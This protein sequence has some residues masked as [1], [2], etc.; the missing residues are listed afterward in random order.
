MADRH[1]TQ[2]RFPSQG[3]LKLREPPLQKTLLLH[4]PIFTHSPI[5]KPLQDRVLTN[6]KSPAPR[7]YKPGGISTPYMAVNLYFG[8][9]R[10]CARYNAL[11]SSLLS[12]LNSAGMEIHTLLGGSAQSSCWDSGTPQ[13]SLNTTTAYNQGVSEA[14][15]AVDR[16][17]E[18]GLASADKT[19]SVVYYDLEGYSATT[20][21]R[22]A[23]KAFITGWVAR[24]HARKF[25]G[26]I[27][28]IMR[29][30]AERLC[31]Y[32]QWARCTLACRNLYIRL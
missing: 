2:L 7:N 4:R 15:L 19:G 26:R 3:H 5:L 22:D 32:Y 23:A 27:W 24:L 16:L 25:R 21:C 14:N 29:I 11:S 8:G 28:F 13:I 1:G 31:S 12:Q 30:P 10:G 18:L 9:D 6:V 17:T 20:G